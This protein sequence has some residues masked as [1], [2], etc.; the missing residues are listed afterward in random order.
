[1]RANSKTGLFGFIELKLFYYDEIIK[2]GIYKHYLSDDG[3]N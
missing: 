2:W 1:M 3:A